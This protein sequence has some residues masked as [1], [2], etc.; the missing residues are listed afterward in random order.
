MLLWGE[1]SPAWTRSLQL[2]FDK[3]KPRWFVMVSFLTL[4]R[5]QNTQI[6]GENPIS[7]FAETDVSGKDELYHLFELGSPSLPAFAHQS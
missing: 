5:V 3:T 4:T 2:F 1:A 7:A 6:D